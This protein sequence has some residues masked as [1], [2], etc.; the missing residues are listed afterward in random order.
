MVTLRL[1]AAIPG[2][3]LVALTLRS[4]VRTFVLP[5]SARDPITRGVFYAT[6]LLFAGR[7]R[8]ARGYLARDGVMALYAPFTVLGL[9]A[10]WVGLV[11][12]GYGI[13]YWALG[14]PVWR[15]F[16]LSGSTLLT[17]GY[18]KP[19]DEPAMIVAFSEGAIGLT[20]VALLVSYLPAMY[21]AFARRE[22]LVTMLEIRA[23]A[24]PEAAELL[25]R[26]HQLGGMEQIDLLWAEWQQWF[27]E[28]EES[29]T[30]LG[31][32]SFFR[33]PQPH[34]SWVTA[35]GAAL[36]AVSLAGAVLRRGPSAQERLTLRAGA[37]SLRRIAEFF[38]IEFDPHPDPSGPVSVRRHEFDGAYRQ[39]VDADLDVCTDPEQAWADFVAARAQYDEVL[40]ALAALTMAPSAPWSSDRAERRRSRLTPGG[41]RHTDPLAG[42]V[43][44]T[45]DDRVRAV[46]SA[47]PRTPDPTALDGGLEPRESSATGEADP[48]GDPAARDQD[49]GASP[50]SDDGEAPEDA[51]RDAGGDAHEGGA[52]HGAAPAHQQSTP[53]ADR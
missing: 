18:E 1:A 8:F 6:R 23:G 34:R 22:A 41:R 44:A 4:A 27:V 9:M 35:A 5:R 49:A 47:T 48:A 32:L 20:M 40:L 31:A 38:A 25:V 52:D 15:A 51:R 16:N 24:P 2:L 19:R 33:S 12:L 7:L 11:G 28:L 50:A 39:L 13:T 37:F 14:E 46:P 3:L 29:H 36:D 21:T 43:P 30:S 10:C 45:G 53:G 17:L 26:T 42:P